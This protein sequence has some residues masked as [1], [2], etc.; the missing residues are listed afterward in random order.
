MAQVFVAEV[1]NYKDIRGQKPGFDDIFGNNNNSKIN[2]SCCA[3]CSPYTGIRQDSY[4][5]P[6]THHH[7][8]FSTLDFS[9]HSY[10]RRRSQ[11]G[12]VVGRYAA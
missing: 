4:S 7:L 9:A 6:F 12:A 5:F 3:V 10:Q 11:T 1:A 8:A 2:K